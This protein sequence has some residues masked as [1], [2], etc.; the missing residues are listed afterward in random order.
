MSTSAASSSSSAFKRKRENTAGGS[1]PTST[2]Y[3]DGTMASTTFA[4]GDCSAPKV[5]S[6]D[7]YGA[8]WQGIYRDLVAGKHAVPS[9]HMVAT[10]ANIHLK[11]LNDYKSAQGSLQRATATYN[12]FALSAAG[13]APALVTNHL[14]LPSYQLV[15]SA[16]S[17]DEDPATAT[18]HIST[19]YA[20]QVEHCRTMTDANAMSW[21]TAALVDT[22]RYETAV[23]LLKAALMKNSALKEAKAVTLAN[24]R[25]DAEMTDATKPVTETIGEEIQKQLALQRAS[26]SSL[27]SNVTPAN[28]SILDASPRTARYDSE[29]QRLSH[30]SL[31]ERPRFVIFDGDQA[32]SEEAERAVET[33][34]ARAAKAS[35]S[36]AKVKQG[37]NRG[38][39]GGAKQGTSAKGKGKAKQTEEESDSSS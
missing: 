31:L 9:P 6:T 30:H 26:P 32:G 17:V 14:K 12:G 19:V 20:V 33:Q 2:F 18:K 37:A 38:S 34:A 7:Q 35:T 16:P 15:K 22:D 1:I 36:N 4:S 21:R 11:S 10:F 27:V 39:A 8:V 23:A 29:G 24:A 13:G 28:F 5:V 3:S 25:A